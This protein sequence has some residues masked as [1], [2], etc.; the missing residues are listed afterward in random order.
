MSLINN[1]YFI[2]RLNI[3]NLDRIENSEQ[4]D[5]II[6]NY[7]QEMLE[8]FMGYE[9]LSSFTNG[10][11]S[12]PID[13]KW[14]NIL[15]G[16]EFTSSC[17]RQKKWKGLISK[18]AALPTVNATLENLFFKVGD[19]NAPIDGA[20][21]YINTSIAGRKYIVTQR[22]FGPLWDGYDIDVN[23]TGGFSLLNGHI[24]S[25]D[26]IFYIQ[27]LDGANV[28]INPNTNDS[29]L[30][31][32]VLTVDG[33]GTNPVNSTTV[34]NNTLLA[35]KAYRVHQ[36]GFG[37]LHN[38]VEINKISTGGFELL[39]GQQFASNDVYDIQFLNT[40]IVSGGSN[41]TFKL[42]ES[43]IAE[44]IYYCWL[45]ENVTQTTYSEVMTKPENA[46]NTSPAN[47][48]SRAYNRF[49]KEMLVL[50]DYLQLNYTL[51][52]EFVKG[53]IDRRKL[54]TLINPYNL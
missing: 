37:F 28:V 42:P 16:V 48:M 49:V 6:Y 54:L 3:P 38:G 11:S 31:D 18:N 22:G 20:S 40:E 33:G 45:K 47:K 23:D 46:V 25:Q 53:C 7:E 44:Y 9:L 19:D 30:N 2:G 41:A 51:Y 5:A 34:Y 52:P 27:F 21:S 26:D 32:I 43:P 39:N 4:M 17:G 29:I 35:N 10:L 14:L 1:S 24:F 15:F 12:N 8:R 13:S 50:E 36:R